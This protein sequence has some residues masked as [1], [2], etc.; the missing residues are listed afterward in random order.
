MPCQKQPPRRRRLRGRERGVTQVR[1]ESEFLGI[2]PRE[3][4]GRETGRNNDAV[5]RLACALFDADDSRHRESILSASLRIFQNYRAFMFMAPLKSRFAIALIPSRCFRM[6]MLLRATQRDVSRTQ[7]ARVLDRNELS[8]HVIVIRWGIKFSGV[9]KRGITSAIRVND[10]TLRHYR[11]LGRGELF[12][13]GRKTRPINPQPRETR[14]PP[15]SAISCS[16]PPSSRCPLQR[17]GICAS[18]CPPVCVCSSAD[19]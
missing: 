18:V 17:A 5:T 7:R 9:D 2:I 10:A 16:P 4:H 15:I 8:I 3:L 13:A 12:V 1:G 14:Q 19:R 11:Q 6:R